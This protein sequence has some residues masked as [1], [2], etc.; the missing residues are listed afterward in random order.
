[1]RYFIAGSP[2]SFSHSFTGRATAGYI[3]YDLKE[4]G[5][6]FMKDAWRTDVPGL[7]AEYQ[8]LALLGQ[9]MI[10]SEGKTEDPV[11]HVPRL[12]CGGDL[13]D[14]NGEPQVTRTTD[15][16]DEE[17][18]KRPAQRYT[19]YR[20]VVKEVGKKLV[21]FKSVPNLLSVLKD[22]VLGEL[23]GLLLNA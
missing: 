19:H 7:L 1:M 12:L 8:V 22:T 23:P 11:P 4:E 17:G 9:E 16:F 14:K 3:C 6:H 10:D 13:L 20:M 15:V 18:K 5:V 2:I 21:S